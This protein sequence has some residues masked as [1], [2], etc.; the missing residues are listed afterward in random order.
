MPCL[1]ALSTKRVSI[2]MWATG[3]LLIAAQV[4]GECFCRCNLDVLTTLSLD[5]NLRKSRKVL[6]HIEHECSL[7]YDMLCDV[8]RPLSLCF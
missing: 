7:W 3:L 5:G 1:C 4:V 8:L 2:I 6:S